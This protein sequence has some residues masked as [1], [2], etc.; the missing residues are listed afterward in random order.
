MVY[1]WNSLASIGGLNKLDPAAVGEE[2]E[3][4]QK[5]CGETFD[6]KQ[7]VD[8]ARD[9][10]SSLHAGFEWDDSKAAE[11]H[12]LNQARH[13]IGCLVVVTMDKKNKSREYRACVSTD[14]DKKRAYTSM[15]RV[16]N[17][18]YLKKQL[19]D[20]ALNEVE[21]WQAR[22]AMYAELTDINVAITQTKKKLK[23]SGQTMV[24]GAQE[25]A[26]GR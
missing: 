26:V 23:K 5:A 1:K 9:E 8:V 10:K 21:A 7:V 2:V 18:E 4:I 20:R 19:L 14:Q 17:S 6:A 13:L 24:K 11:E 15:D 16:L 22:Y 12:R 25:I 3:K